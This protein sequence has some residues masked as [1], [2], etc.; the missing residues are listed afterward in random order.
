M[1]VDNEVIGIQAEKRELID[2]EVFR[3]ER[4]FVLHQVQDFAYWKVTAL[5][6]GKDMLDLGCNKGYGCELMSSRAGHVIGV[7]VSE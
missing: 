6:D 7:D 2:A 3:S 1:L 5:V 4:D